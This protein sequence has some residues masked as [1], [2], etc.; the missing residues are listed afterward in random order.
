MPR[1]SGKLGVVNGQK[2]VATWTIT[3]SNNTRNFKLSNTSAGTGRKKGTGDWTGSFMSPEP[4]PVSMP[5]DLITFGGYLGPTTGVP[6]ATGPKIDCGG[7][8]ENIAMTWD[9]EANSIDHTTNFACAGQVAGLTRGTGTYTDATNPTLAIPEGLLVKY[10]TTLADLNSAVY[11]LG[12]VLLNVTKV[13]LTIT[14]A[15]PRFV[16]SHTNGWAGRI[17]GP[18]D[19]TAAITVNEADST[20]LPQIGTNLILILPINA[21]D[22]WGLRFGHVDSFSGI[23]VDNNTGAIISQTINIGMQANSGSAMG[24]ITKPAAGSAWWPWTT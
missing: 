23:T 21:I 17:R 15:N 24:A 1:I 12:S 3:E 7:I 22:Y 2:S 11:S 20:I 16:D 13:V 5:G 10:S 9:W 8:I 4:V 18:L 14:C 19:W 6:G